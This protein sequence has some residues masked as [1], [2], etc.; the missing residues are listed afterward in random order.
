MLLRHCVRRAASR[1]ACTAGNNNDTRT[2]MIA[3]TTNSSINVNAAR[4]RIL[5]L[6]PSL[7]FRGDF[8]SC[9]AFFVAD[10]VLHAVVR[11]EIVLGD[12]FD[13]PM[14]VRAFPRL[15]QDRHRLCRW[16]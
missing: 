13:F 7:S 12:E 3:I 10:D 15:V 11:D 2:A 5:A 9:R 4:F 14:A 1:A 6:S 8:L 16:I